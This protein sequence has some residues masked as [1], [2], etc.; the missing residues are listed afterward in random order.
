MER[1]RSTVDTLPADARDRV[2]LLDALTANRRT[3]SRESFRV[4]DDG[5]LVT[6][7]VL[8]DDD[9]DELH[10]ELLGV[11]EDVRCLDRNGRPIL[12]ARFFRDGRRDAGDHVVS[13]TDPWPEGEAPIAVEFHGALACP[14]RRL[15]TLLELADVASRS[16]RVV[17][18]LNLP[19]P[20]RLHAEVCGA[21]YLVPIKR[22]KAGPRLPEVL[23]E[24]RR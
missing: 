16:G 6:V 22:E 23:S 13:P 15:E 5:D 4:G 14:P 9:D 7:E 3:P 11:V 17:Y 19:A 2:T 21:P 12:Q 10:D 8:I 1:E 20:L 24:S 18:F